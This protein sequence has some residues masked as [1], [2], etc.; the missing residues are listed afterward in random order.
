MTP[1]LRRHPL[2]MSTRTLTMGLRQGIDIPSTGVKIRQ[3]GVK[4]FQG[5]GDKD[6]ISNL[7]KGILRKID[8]HTI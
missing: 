4:L 6:G 8:I 3:F 1:P 5:L 2:S 7:K